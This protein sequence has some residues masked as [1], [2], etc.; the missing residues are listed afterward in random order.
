MNVVIVNETDPEVT[1]SLKSIS[2]E[3]VKKSPPLCLFDTH[4]HMNFCKGETYRAIPNGKQADNRFF[5]SSH[6][7]YRG[8]CHV[9]Y[10]WCAFYRTHS[11][12]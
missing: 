12:W 9:T 5:A 3:S 8:M 1:V 7:V 4:T 10:A 2:A 6:Q 11:K